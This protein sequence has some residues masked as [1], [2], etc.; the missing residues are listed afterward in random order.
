MADTRVQLEAEDWI[1]RNWLPQ[2]F[3][4]AFYRERIRLSSGGV[5][6]FDAV[7]ADGTIVASISTSSA[8]TASGKPGVGKLTKIR[9]D[10]LFLLLTKA[11]RRMIV[12][13]ERDMHQLFLREIEGGRVPSSIEFLLAE[14][15]EELARKLQASRTL[16]SREVS[17]QN[18][19]LVR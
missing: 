19:R 2:R 17:P 4:R 13:T 12:L 3:G 7:S 1:R 6:D 15:P 8:T 14:L 16:A 9:A 10:M 11:E 5:H 18:W